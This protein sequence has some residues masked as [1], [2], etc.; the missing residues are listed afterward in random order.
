MQE[1]GNKWKAYVVMCL[2]FWTERTF[3]TDRSLLVYLKS[4]LGVPL[5]FSPNLF[6]T[7]FGGPA[8]PYVFIY[9]RVLSFF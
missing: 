9:L 1:A 6:L 7:R 8:F 3:P 2:D 4:S 5:L